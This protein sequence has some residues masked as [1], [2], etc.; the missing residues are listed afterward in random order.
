MH[1]QDR[2]T[3]CCSCTTRDSVSSIRKSPNL[4]WI[5]HFVLENTSEVLC[6]GKRWK[7]RKEVR[8]WTH[9]LSMRIATHDL[10]SLKD[11]LL[12]NPAL[13]RYVVNPLHGRRCPALRPWC[14]AYVLF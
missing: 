7:R 5:D 2:S 12:P 3:A 8:T 10:R 9:L 14:A 6:R 11:S 1:I 13:E 4:I